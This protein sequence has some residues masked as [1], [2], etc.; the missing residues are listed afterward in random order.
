[1]SIH[2]D[3]LVKI[4]EK[5]APPELMESWDNSGIQLEAG[6]G[7]IEGILVCLDVT[8]ETIGEAVEKGCDF[9]LSHHPLIFTPL[10]QISQASFPGKYITEL[11]RRGIS[12]YSAHT[13]FDSAP[14]GNNDYLAELLGL[15]QISA[16]EGLSIL[17]T[18][19]FPQPVS[20]ERV[21]ALVK[22]R[23][24]MKE[25]VRFAGR[26]DDVIRKAAVCTGAGASLLEEAAALSCQ[27]LITGD[28]KYHDALRGRELGICLVDGGHF[29]TEITFGENMG[30]RLRSMLEGRAR[31]VFAGKQKNPL[32][33]AGAL[34]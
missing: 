26:P 5:I 4:I 3:E 28:V 21:C 9:I 6:S 29:A 33:T 24:S 31:V 34:W 1:M 15:S 8:E 32:K 23:L 30:K 25:P 20:L 16:P 18:G 19:Y 17:R 2:K 7:Q 22:E 13:T 12:V 11:I 14:G 10:K 27:L